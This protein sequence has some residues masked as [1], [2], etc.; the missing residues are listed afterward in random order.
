VLHLRHAGDDLD[1]PGLGEK[2]LRDRAR[3]HA[4]DG[5]A[6]AGPAAALPGTDAELRLV[7]VVRVG[8]PVLGAQLLVVAAPRVL[9]P[10]QHRDPRSERLA[11]VRARED[12]DA[13]GLAP[14]RGEAALTRTAPIE[15]ALHIVLAERE[16]RRTSVDDHP[17]SR[18]VRLAESRHAKRCSERAR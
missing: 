5:L 12:L 10:D 3:R 4:A 18:P 7:R 14:L 6:R 1:A 2:L 11:L 17:D 9:V 13:V 15:L 8:R 16:P